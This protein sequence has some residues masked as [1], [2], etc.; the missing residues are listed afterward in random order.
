M[1]AERQITRIVRSWLRED[2]HESADRILETVLARLDATPQRRHSWSARR[3]TTMNTYAK[4][5]IGAAAAVGIAIAGYNLLPRDSHGGP[6][7]PTPT[8]SP[9]P[10]PTAQVVADGPLAP[11]RWVFTSVASF[12]IE[13]SIPAV[14]WVKNTVP[15]VI[16]TDGSDGRLGFEPG[17]NLVTD[18]CRWQTAGLQSPPVGPAVDDFAMALAQLPGVGATAPANVVLAGYPGKFVE[19]PVT[20][21]ASGCD[22]GERRLTGDAPLEN[23]RHRLWILDVEGER[24]VVHAVERDPLPTVLRNELQQIIDS[25]Q[26]D[27][28]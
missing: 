8:A 23:G 20:G 2:E 11:G 14:G 16:W 24:L 28:I 9:S 15:G 3:S 12:R 21:D 22:G 10:G 6:P 25:I 1:T 17:G 5:A 19:L 7:S 18:P 26:I 27:R 4:F 13:F